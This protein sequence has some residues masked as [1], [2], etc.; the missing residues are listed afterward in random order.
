M[1][2]QMNNEYY[3][4]FKETNLPDFLLQ[5]TIK[6]IVSQINIF[7]YGYQDN[8]SHLVW[9]LPVPT[10]TFSI[11][12][13]IARFETSPPP[14]TLKYIGGYLYSQVFRSIATL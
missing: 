5:V 7:I 6:V 11:A 2:E 3:L 10:C 4:L 12:L 9:T 1:I 8:S 14:Y 13:L